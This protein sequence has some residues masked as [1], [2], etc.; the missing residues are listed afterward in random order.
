MLTCGSPIR[1]PLMPTTVVFGRHFLRFFLNGVFGVFA[2]HSKPDY[3]RS[4]YAFHPCVVS[5][6]VATAPKRSSHGRFHTLQAF[7]LVSNE[8]FSGKFHAQVAI[9]DPSSPGVGLNFPTRD[10]ASSPYPW[11]TTRP[12]TIGDPPV[13]STQT[14]IALSTNAVYNLEPAFCHQFPPNYRSPSSAEPT[15]EMFLVFRQSILTTEQ[16]P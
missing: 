6:A 1:V 10:G 16:Y 3:P 15:T 13:V 12:H 2:P 5:F 11:I 8:S 14:P 7:S 9:S 4:K